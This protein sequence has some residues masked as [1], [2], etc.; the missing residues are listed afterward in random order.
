MKVRR[1]IVCDKE[2]TTTSATKWWCS[3]HDHKPPP[4]K[5]PAPWVPGYDWPEL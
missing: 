1:C 4:P 3:D 2:F 5:P